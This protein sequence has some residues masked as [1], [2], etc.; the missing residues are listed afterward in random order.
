MNTILFFFFA[1]S[2]TTAAFTNNAIGIGAVYSMG[3]ELELSRMSE[4]PCAAPTQTLHPRPDIP[5]GW[6]L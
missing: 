6:G 3:I 4:Q 1:Y 5:G 2:H